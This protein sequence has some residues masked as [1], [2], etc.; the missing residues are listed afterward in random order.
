MDT[1]WKQKLNR[2]TWTQTKDMKQKDLIDTYRTF[3]PKTKG[4]IPSSQHHMV[5][6]PKF[7]I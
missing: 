5:P 4:Y 7:T 3:Y 2:D 1:S 6:P